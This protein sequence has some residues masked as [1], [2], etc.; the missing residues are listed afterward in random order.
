M[1]KNQLSLIETAA[2]FGIPTD[3]TVRCWVKKYEQQG[4]TGLLQDRG[5]RKRSI[6]GKKPKKVKKTSTDSIEE[7]L[8]ALESENEYL[9]AEN[10]FLK[11]MGA[12]IQE[13]KAAQK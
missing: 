13:Q 9:R 12:L 2:L 7:R 1:L 11:K 10:A 3:S 5:G 8:A 4:N 6:M